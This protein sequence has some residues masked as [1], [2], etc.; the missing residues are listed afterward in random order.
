M[1]VTN[2]QESFLRSSFHGTRRWSLLWA[3]TVV[4]VSIGPLSIKGGLATTG[5]LHFFIHVAAFMVGALVAC[6]PSGGRG[7]RTLA[8]TWVA[9]M[10]FL[11]E[12]LEVLV[13][14]NRFEWRDVTADIIGVLLGLAILVIGKAAMQRQAE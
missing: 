14:G 7:H 8:T 9:G 3:L 4:T 13:Y 5:G 10:A 1:P 2:V 6:R 12:Y 11:S